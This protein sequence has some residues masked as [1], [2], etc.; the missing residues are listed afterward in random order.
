MCVSFND[1]TFFFI[2][3][4]ENVSEFAGVNTYQMRELFFGEI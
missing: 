2:K 1:L 4:T 3:Q